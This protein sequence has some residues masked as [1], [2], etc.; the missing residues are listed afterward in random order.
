M[1]VD[2]PFHAELPGGIPALQGQPPSWGAI[3]RGNP[4]I[5]TGGLRADA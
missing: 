2:P 5:K 4:R 3:G 1:I